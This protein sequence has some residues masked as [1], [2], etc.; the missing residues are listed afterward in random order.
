MSLFVNIF[1]IKI[2]I[3]RELYSIKMF[4]KR[5]REE[6]SEKLNLVIHRVEQYKQGKSAI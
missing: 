6:N 2:V 1:L 5:A 3:K 4:P